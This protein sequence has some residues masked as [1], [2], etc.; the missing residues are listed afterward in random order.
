[1]DKEVFFCFVMVLFLRDFVCGMF[2]RYFW[3]IQF[4]RMEFFCFSDIFDNDCYDISILILFC[5]Q[6]G[7]F[8]YVN[9][10]FCFF[11]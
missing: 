3:N 8:I 7:F 4:C 9:E 11:Y 6:I 10:D 2:K 5:L 1:M